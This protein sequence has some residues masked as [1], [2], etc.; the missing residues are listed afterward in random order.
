[1]D[2]VENLCAVVAHSAGITNAYDNFF[3]NDKA[4]FVLKSLAVNFL[5]THDTVAALA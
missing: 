1:M 5:R 2:S 3:E 4:L